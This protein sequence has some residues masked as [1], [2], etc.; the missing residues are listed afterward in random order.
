CL[1]AGDLAV[2]SA[3]ALS[4]REISPTAGRLFRR[5]VLAPGADFEV[6]AA[7]ALLGAPAESALEELAGASLIGLAAVPGRYRLHD[8]LRLYASELLQEDEQQVEYALF[9]WLFGQARAAAAALAPESSDYPGGRAAALAWLDAEASALLGAVRRTGERVDGELDPLLRDLTQRIPW[10]YDLR[11][12][13]SDMIEVAEH[14]RVAADRST[15]LAERAFAHSMLGLGQLGQHQY[16]ASLASCELG[17]A[18]ARAAGLAAEEAELFGRLGLAYEGLGRYSEAE[19]RHADHAEQCRVLGDQWGEAAAIG[20]RSHALQMLGKH[21]EAA[22]CLR[23]ALKMRSGLGDERGVA[24]AEYRFS[25]LRNDQGN[26]EEALQRARRALT[27]FKSHDDHWGTA[28]VHYELGRSLAG[29]NRLRE[30]TAAYR[31]AVQ[32]LDEVGEWQRLAEATAALTDA[33]ARV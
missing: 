2:R 8:L 9:D 5:L 17:L 4:Y 3:F 21:T 19:A 29:L 32:G 1:T 28:V 14:A 27:I 10:Y 31:T 13:W 24:M 30:A 11:C 23:R 18:D 12:R 6:Q 22:A 16:R 25:A 20:R 7:T 33:Q 26:Y 15:N